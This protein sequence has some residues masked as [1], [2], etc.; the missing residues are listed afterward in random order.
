MCQHFGNK[1]N[2]VIKSQR[3]TVTEVRFPEGTGPKDANTSVVKKI[4]I[5]IAD[6]YLY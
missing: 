6:A 5:K 4:R 1:E 3:C 2:Q